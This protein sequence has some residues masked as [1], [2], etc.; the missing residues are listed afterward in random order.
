M[1]WIR[2]GSGRTLAAILAHASVN[3]ALGILVVALLGSLVETTN[4]WGLGITL[5]AAA[6]AL[7]TRGQ[8]GM[9][10]EKKATIAGIRPN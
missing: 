9:G 2:D 7:V 8:L 4:W 5:A 10:A 3:G 1:A 6:V